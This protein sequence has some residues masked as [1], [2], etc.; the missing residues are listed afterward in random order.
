VFVLLFGTILTNHMVGAVARAQTLDTIF[1]LTVNK[2]PRS[3]LDN[4]DSTN[5]A[6][7]SWL[8]RRARTAP[9]GRL[10]Q[11]Q[12]CTGDEPM[13]VQPQE[14]GGLTIAE[15]IDRAR[16]N[17]RVLR[18]K[19]APAGKLARMQQ[20]MSLLDDTHEGKHNLPR[21]NCGFRLR[22]GYKNPEAVTRCFKDR[23][24]PWQFGHLDV[25]NGEE[26]KR[27]DCDITSL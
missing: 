26:G 1:G 16:A 8:W 11:M 27:R 22:S 12:T 18:S 2:R 13:G 15:H 25:S 3:G 14:L 5:Q 6:R 4:A 21:S 24:D 23:V 10:A 17:R 19:S 20:A 7:V 9:D